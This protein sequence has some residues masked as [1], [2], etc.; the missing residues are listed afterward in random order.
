MFLT[1]FLPQRHQ[2]VARD[3]PPSLQPATHLATSSPASVQ[4]FLSPTGTKDGSPRRQPGVPGA[5]DTTPAPGGAK[6]SC[7]LPRAFDTSCATN[8]S[9]LPGLLLLD[10]LKPTADAVGY[11]YYAPSGADAGV[12][13]RLVACILYGACTGMSALQPRSVGHA[14]ATRAT[15]ASRFSI[16]RVFLPVPEADRGSLLR[17]PSSTRSCGR[18]GELLPEKCG[19]VR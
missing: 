15:V 16:D 10:A 2:G 7:A 6:E 4:Q 1:V 12:D 19:P 18:F 11:P 17:F 14:H 9:P 13:P 3:G 5:H 8:L